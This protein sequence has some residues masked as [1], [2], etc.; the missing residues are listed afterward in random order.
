MLSSEQKGICTPAAPC[1]CVIFS[2]SCPIFSSVAEPTSG[3]S[4]PSTAGEFT[5]SSAHSSSTES[6]LSENPFQ[7][8][9]P[10]PLPVVVDIRPEHAFTESHVR[11]SY[12]VPLPET[13]TDF[14]DDA[15]AVEKRWWELK[16][17]IDGE[18]WPHSPC[19]QGSMVRSTNTSKEKDGL[20][21]EAKI[22]HPSPDYSAYPDLGPPS[23]PVIVLCSDGDSGKM[24]TSILRGKGQ[25]AYCVEGGYRELLQYLSR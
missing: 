2:S 14:Y 20:T 16:N 7:T 21:E 6:S 19:P 11:C 5:W 23:S 12:N 18:M 13:Q 15:Q 1:Q 25:E 3:S 4:S 8:I 22:A 10:H 17:A 9:I 24:A